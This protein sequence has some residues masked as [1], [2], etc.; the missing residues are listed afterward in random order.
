MRKRSDPVNFNYHFINTDE[1]EGKEKREHCT[2]HIG[3]SRHPCCWMD[4]AALKIKFDM[5]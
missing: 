1:D 2:T 5:I 3:H 4:K